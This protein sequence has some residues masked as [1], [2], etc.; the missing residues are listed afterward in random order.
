MFRWDNLYYRETFIR[1]G[2]DNCKQTEINLTSLKFSPSFTILYSS[3]YHCKWFLGLSEGKNFKIVWLLFFVCSR[4]WYFSWIEREV[5]FSLLS[6]EITEQFHLMRVIF[7]LGWQKTNKI[8]KNIETFDKRCVFEVIND[9]T[10]HAQK[11]SWGEVKIKPRKFLDLI[12][13]KTVKMCYDMLT[14]CLIWLFAS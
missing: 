2:W 11:V 13:M 6:K 12:K 10:R 4:D 9:L 7:L 14:T 1:W 8:L 5:F 3:N